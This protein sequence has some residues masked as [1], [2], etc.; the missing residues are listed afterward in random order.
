M[1]TAWV[2]LLALVAVGVS[3]VLV[4]SANFD[5]DRSIALLNVSY[6]AT[7]ELFQDLNK[8]FETKYQR[9]TGRKIAIQQ[10]HGGSARQARAIADGLAADVVTLALF[11]D[12]D[13]LSKRG[14]IA[15][16][17]SK[18]LPHESQPWSSTIV[19]VV[20][21]GNPRK[22]HDWP[23]LLQRGLLVITPD[24]K[25]S[26]NGKLSVL[27]A[28]GS[29][30][31]RGGTEAQAREYVRRLYENVPVLDAG[32]RGAAITFAGEKTGDVHL[33]WEN[34]A[35]REVADSGGELEIV[36][37]S[38]S[39]LAE[40]SVAWLDENV[41][42][43]HTGEVAKAYLE[44]L[45]TEPAQ[46]IIAAHGYRPIDPEVLKKHAATLPKIELFPITT[47]AKDWNDAQQK[48]FG[49]N[50]IFDAIGQRRAKL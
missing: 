48:F 1:K 24:P 50:G 45:F 8:Q 49:E 21:Q 39:I 17:W 43:R 25:T 23:D 27:A 29:V 33:T 10:S 47:L 37:P 16:G 41:A 28:W 36:Y 4:V 22:I 46:E 5:R 35:L 7:R 9:E 6:D 12:V 44:F 31:H 3:A 26:G 20:R 14:L 38:A 40:P 11:S 18:R 13:T 15:P 2:N 32:A 34:E 42:K 19:F 30:I